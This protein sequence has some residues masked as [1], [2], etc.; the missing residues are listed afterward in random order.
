MLYAGTWRRI[1]DSDC[2]Q[3]LDDD[4]YFIFVFFHRSDCFRV[5][6]IVKVLQTTDFQLQMAPKKETV[7]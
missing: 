2:H 7:Y 4:M 1:V 3:E 5:Y 6:R